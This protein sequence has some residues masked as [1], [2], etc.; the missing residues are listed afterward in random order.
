MTSTLKSCMAASGLAFIVSLAASAPASALGL[1]EC[2]E[3]YNAAKAAGTL[4]ALD[5][6]AFRKSACAEA[7]APALPATAAAAAAAAPSDAASA[8]AKAQTPSAHVS[9]P[10]AAPNGAA[11]FPLVI[12]AQFASERPVTARMHTCLAQYKAN[13]AANANGGLRW[14]EK[15]G[16]YY[17]QCNKRLKGTAACR[18]PLPRSLIPEN[19]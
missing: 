16:G 3:K 18:A 15:G 9:P 10:A 7:G 6:T 19:A 1:K 12:A 13:K 2:A 4:G 17:S 11:V 8:T 5:W 14:I